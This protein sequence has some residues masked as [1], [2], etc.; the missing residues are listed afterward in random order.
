MKEEIKELDVVALLRDHPEKGL[1]AGQV[2]TVVE[3]LDSEVFEVEFND[4]EGRTYAIGAFDRDSI[5]AL[6]YHPVAA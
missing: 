1:V 6:H 4:D 2:G 3:K 5:I